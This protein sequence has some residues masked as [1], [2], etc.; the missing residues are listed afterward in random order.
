MIAMTHLSDISRALSRPHL[1][2]CAD[3]IIADLMNTMAQHTNPRPLD[4]VAPR[5]AAEADTLRVMLVA[6]ERLARKRL[7]INAGDLIQALIDGDRAATEAATGR[8]RDNAIEDATACLRCACDDLAD[9]WAA[10]MQ[11]G[12]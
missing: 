9:E 7:G 11:G 6:T 2:V 8:D 1:D 4:M 3:A 10:N 12:V 5:E